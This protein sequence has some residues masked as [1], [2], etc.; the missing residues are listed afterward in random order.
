MVEQSSAPLQEVLEWL[1]PAAGEDPCG[2]WTTHFG[3]SARV[4]RWLDVE[5]AV[6]SALPSRPRS[7]VGFRFFPDAPVSVHTAATRSANF[8]ML[9]GCLHGAPD[10]D[11]GA[12][13]T[14]LPA[15]SAITRALDGLR[16][17]GGGFGELRVTAGRRPGGDERRDAIAARLG[18]PDRGSV[19][20]IVNRGGVLHVLGTAHVAHGALRWVTDGRVNVAAVGATDGAAGV[21]AEAVGRSPRAFV[22]SGVGVLRAADGGLQYRI[23][24]NCECV[25]PWRD[26]AVRVDVASQVAQMGSGWAG[27]TAGTSALARIQGLPFEAGVYVAADSRA[28]LGLQLGYRTPSLHCA[29]TA[30]GDLL[31]GKLGAPSI[32]VRLLEPQP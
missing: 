25:L 7:H 15:S 2:S 21:F 18:Q 8:Y 10:G 16:R 4:L 5:C 23:A 1:A 29:V 22:S 26:R 32:I 19:G 24:T 12:T 31:T 30:W 20:V 13:S 3:G 17:R 9:R 14:L 6:R 11:D 27:V 28:S